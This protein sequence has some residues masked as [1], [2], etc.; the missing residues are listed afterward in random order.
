MPV[1]IGQTRWL[2]FEQRSTSFSK[3]LLAIVVCWLTVI[4]V[5]FGLYTKP[6]AT[7]TTALF[8][9]ALSVSTAIFLVLEMYSPYTGLIRIPMAPLHTVLDQ[10]G[11]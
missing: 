11:R 8:V 3:P 9:G 1:D 4:F 2:M 10:L 6:N 7:V 5:S